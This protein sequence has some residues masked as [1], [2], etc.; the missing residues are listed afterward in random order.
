DLPC[1]VLEITAVNSPDAG[2]CPQTVTRTYTVTEYED[3]NNNGIRDSGENTI[4][5]STN[6][7]QSIIVQDL[8]A[9]TFVEAL[10]A[11]TTV[12]CDAVPTAVTLTATD[13]C[14]AATV[15]YNET[16]AAGACTN[17]YTLTREWTATDACGL[18]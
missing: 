9:P 12:N 14:G 10:P 7:T 11:D 5:N 6:C 3:P 15:T 13:N 16:T 18:T 17:N 1:G 2:T 8:T 4:W